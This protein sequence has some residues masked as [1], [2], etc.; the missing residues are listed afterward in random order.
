MQLCS[1]VCGLV[2]HGLSKQKN[3]GRRGSQCHMPAFPWQVQMHSEHLSN[4]TKQRCALG[5]DLTFVRLNDCDQ[6]G[7][8]ILKI[9]LDNCPWC[10]AN[11]WCLHRKETEKWF[12]AKFSTFSIPKAMIATNDIEIIDVKPDLKVSWCCKSPIEGRD[13][14]LPKTLKIDF[15]NV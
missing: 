8:V 7:I 9:M 2:S 1:C 5:I 11:H 15:A 13:V 3:S 10:R 14:I 6:Y 12:V 4:D